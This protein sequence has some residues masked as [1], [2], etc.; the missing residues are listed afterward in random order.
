MLPITIAVT[1]PGDRRR[2]QDRIPSHKPSGPQ[3]TDARTAHHSL[4]ADSSGSSSRL[5]SGKNEVGYGL[6]VPVGD[7]G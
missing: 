1:A 5:S 6:V 4:T 7:S 2:R 3:S